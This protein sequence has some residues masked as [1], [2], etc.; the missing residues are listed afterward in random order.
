[1]TYIKINLDRVRGQNC[2]LPGTCYE[3]NAVC[4][5]IRSA[6]NSIDGDV[7]SEDGSIKSRIN[8]SIRRLGEVSKRIAKL[9]DFV[10]ESVDNYVTT[11]HKLT[12]DGKNI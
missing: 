6:K 1:M 2:A 10:E 9:H 7:F 5:R 11:E 4:D 8:D 12:Y 3:I